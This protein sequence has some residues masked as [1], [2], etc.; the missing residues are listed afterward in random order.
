MIGNAR[1]IP[2]LVPSQ[3]AWSPQ[4]LHTLDKLYATKPKKPKLR[5]H[6][7]EV[8]SPYTQ[9]TQLLQSQSAPPAGQVVGIP[10]TFES[11]LNQV[12]SKMRPILWGL[13]LAG[14]LLLAWRPVHAFMS[15]LPAEGPGAVRKELQARLEAKKDQLLPLIIGMD[16]EL[17]I[18][19]TLPED[20]RLAK[21]N[22]FD[23][24]V[25][26]MTA[27]QMRRNLSESREQA[28]QALI[29]CDDLLGEFDA[30]LN[31]TALTPQEKVQRMASI[32]DLPPDIQARVKRWLMKGTIP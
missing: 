30:L 9:E 20:L 11:S 2:S 24:K 1:P 13:F 7:I 5:V 19:R 31:D 14:S 8:Q 10:P 4:S 17:E 18:V 26:A 16:E 15:G 21:L 28:R 12:R 25:D 32:R 22:P 3:P 27:A 23:G 29:R 6:R